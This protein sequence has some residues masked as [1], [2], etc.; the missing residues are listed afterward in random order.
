MRIRVIEVELDGADASAAL[1]QQFERLFAARAL[2]E[3]ATPPMVAVKAL[4][5]AAGAGRPRGVPGKYDQAALKALAFRPCTVAQLADA[6]CRDKRDVP[7]VTVRLY[8]VLKRLMRDG[9]VTKSGTTYSVR[10]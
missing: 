8:T 6:I 2:P 3:L 5:P 1:A 9:Q 7:V 4:P 10:K